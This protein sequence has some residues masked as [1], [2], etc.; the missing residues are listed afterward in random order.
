MRL[1][2]HHQQWWFVMFV[3]LLWRKPVSKCGNSSM[4]VFHPLLDRIFSQKNHPDSISQ[5]KGYWKKYVP[6][7]DNQWLGWVKCEV[8]LSSFWP[9]YNV[10]RLPTAN[11]LIDRIVAG[12]GPGSSDYK[13]YFDASNVVC[14]RY[15]PMFWD[16]PQPSLHQNKT[17]GHVIF[18]P[19]LSRF[20]KIQLILVDG[21]PGFPYNKVREPPNLS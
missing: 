5:G 1:E 17:A 20:R 10:Q 11:H 9:V 19:N 12:Q 21:A 2:R 6:R 15:F 18:R 14:G 8:C 16:S 13:V 7:D 4:M 3:L